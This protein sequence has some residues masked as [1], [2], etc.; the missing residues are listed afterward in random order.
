MELDAVVEAEPECLQRMKSEVVELMV[1]DVSY[2]AEQVKLAEVEE[3]QPVTMREVTQDNVA[4]TMVD[5]KE[6]ASFGGV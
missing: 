4:E 5:A 6:E 1:L 3:V 2:V